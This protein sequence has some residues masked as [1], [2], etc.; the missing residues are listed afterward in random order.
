M[1]TDPPEEKFIRLLLCQAFDD[2]C[3]EMVIGGD[4]AAARNS[5]P[6][7]YKVGGVW[8]DLSPFPQEMRQ[9]VLDRLWQMAELSTEGGF[10]KQGVF[11]SGIG[12][13]QVEWRLQMQS[14]DSPMV[15]TP[16]SGEAGAP[17]GKSI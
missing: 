10:P 16:V 8:Y 7:R 15:L 12:G 1:P 9:R 11:A 6:I 3:T 13:R 14:I 17:P 4:A 2:G 5:V